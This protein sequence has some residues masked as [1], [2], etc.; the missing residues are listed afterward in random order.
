[1]KLLLIPMAFMCAV[2]MIDAAM[3]QQQPLTDWRASLDDDLSKLSMPRDAHSQVYNIL[4]AYERRAQIEKMR[5]QAQPITPV[6]P[7]K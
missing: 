4:Q 7:P 6:E 3:A 1:M 5:Q 2:L